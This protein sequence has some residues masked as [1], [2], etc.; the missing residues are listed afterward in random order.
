MELGG[1]KTRAA[2]KVDR[3]AFAASPEPGTCP[4]FGNPARFRKSR[5]GPTTGK[6]KESKKKNGQ[7]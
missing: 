3:L 7:A 4:S 1:K 5:T 2:L 6:T